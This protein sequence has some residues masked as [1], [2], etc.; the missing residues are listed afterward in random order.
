M[1]WVLPIHRPAVLVERTPRILHQSPIRPLVAIRDIPL[2]PSN[3]VAF[4][5]KRT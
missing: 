3:R 1:R 4:G 2:L 5:V